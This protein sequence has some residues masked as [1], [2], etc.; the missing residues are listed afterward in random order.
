MTRR[1][2]KA[3]GLWGLLLRAV[4]PVPRPGPVDPPEIGADAGIVAHLVLA[5]ALGL[6]MI[7]LAHHG[8]RQGASWAIWLYWGGVV[9]IFLPAATRLAWPAVSRSERVAVLLL[10]AF[11]T[12]ALRLLYAPTAF[13]EHDE[14]LHWVTAEDILRSRRLFL[15]NPLLPVSPL[16]PGIEIVTTALANVAGLSIFAAA[17]IV[18][19]VLRVTFVA[20]LFCFYDRVFRSPRL[21]SL[22]CLIYMG[23]SAFPSFD[24]QFSYES[25][26]IVFLVLAL[27]AETAILGQRGRDRWA[28]LVLTLAFLAAMAVTH[29]MS[30]YVAASLMV[31]L[32]ILEFLRLGPRSEWW[33]VAIAAAGAVALP[34]IWSWLMGNPSAGYLMP[35]LESG[36]RELAAVVERSSGERELFVAKDG[37]RT[38]LILRLTAVAGVALL[39]LA[40][41]T[42]FLRSLAMS[43]RETRRGRWRDMVAVATCNWRHSWAVLLA[44]VALGFPLAIALRL[45]SSGWEIGNRMGPFVFLG[46]AFVAA[47]AVVFFWQGRRPSRGVTVMVGLALCCIFLGGYI[48]GSGVN[49]VRSPYK[50]SADAASVEPMGR[51][52]A[53]WTRI[54]LGEGNRFAADRVNRLLLASYGAQEVQTTLHGGSDLSGL[55]FSPRLEA[56]EMAAITRGKIDYLLVDLRLSLGLPLFGFYFDQGEAGGRDYPEPP[57]PEAMLKFNAIPRV[58]RIF[59]NGWIAIFD[60]RSLRGRE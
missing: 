7:A 9:A 19:C 13:A 41:V 33:P 59:D 16:Y 21:A 14:F 39:A 34:M 24:T 56:A 40:L 26:A 47:N 23:N 6:L 15:D 35:L 32:A 30:S 54:W 37:S 49:A 18:V 31:G 46:A 60:V 48:A 22:G 3:G 17:A 10:L 4:G 38:P 20:A 28:M 42:G 36:L 11:S 51:E 50:V 55:F 43:V 52:V 29:H 57:D 1:R 45:T 5:M 2:A 8:G 53:G 44:L 12:F 25:L 58:S 27:L